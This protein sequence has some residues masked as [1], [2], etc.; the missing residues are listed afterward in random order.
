MLFISKKS[1][2]Y[3]LTHRWKV[4]GNTCFKERIE[5]M[6]I[7]TYMKINI[8]FLKTQLGHYVAIVNVRWNCVQ[9]SY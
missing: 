9:F 5:T 8:I 3:Q 2:C 4:N 7:N 1:K 6:I